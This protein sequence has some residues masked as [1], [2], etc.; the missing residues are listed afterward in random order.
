MKVAAVSSMREK[1]RVVSRRFSSGHGSRGLLRRD[2][3]ERNKN[4]CNLFI[5]SESCCKGGSVCAR[6]DDMLKY[7]KN[8]HPAFAQK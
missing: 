4:Q 3:S 6:E 5:N 1:V 7:I 2:S 8:T